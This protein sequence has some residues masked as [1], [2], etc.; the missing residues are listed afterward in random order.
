MKI[1]LIT[2]IT[3][4][5]VSGCTTVSQPK[6][7][8]LRPEQESIE[9]STIIK[10]NTAE[11]F[12]GERSLIVNNITLKAGD[13]YYTFAVNGPVNYSNSDNYFF[14]GDTYVYLTDQPQGCGLYSNDDETEF[15]AVQQLDENAYV[16]IKGND[17]DHI[18]DILS[19][20]YVSDGITYQMFDHNIAEEWT[21]EVIITDDVVSLSNGEDTVYIYHNEGS[22]DGPTIFYKQLD[23]IDIPITYPEEGFGFNYIP[24]GFTE[25]DHLIVEGYTPYSAY[26]FGR[27]EL[28]LQEDESDKVKHYR[29]E[30]TEYGSAFIILAKD[31]E[32]LYSLFEEKTDNNTVSAVSVDFSDEKLMSTDPE[33]K[34]KY[35]L[36]DVKNIAQD[37]INSDN[38]YHT[39]LLL[40]DGHDVYVTYTRSDT[41]I[42]SRNNC[43]LTWTLMKN[44]ISTSEDYYVDGQEGYIAPVH[45]VSIEQYYVHNNKTINIYNQ[46]ETIYGGMESKFI[47][48]TLK[49]I[50]PAYTGKTSSMI[51]ETNMPENYGS[52][53]KQTDIEKMVFGEE[54]YWYHSIGLAAHGS[55]FENDAYVKYKSFNYYFNFGIREKIN[56]GDYVYLRKENELYVY[57]CERNEVSEF[58]SGTFNKYVE[59]LQQQGFSYEL[60]TRS[61]YVDEYIEDEEAV[62][63]PGIVNAYSLVSVINI[64]Q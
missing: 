16:R 2:L 37:V 27:L 3:M 44:Y 21:K 33:Q 20:I 22:P 12:E 52:S 17:L 54:N 35:D 60:Y 53:L 63:G 39:K 1:P 55:H 30:A 24:Y 45:T 19:N 32:T 10:Y 23:N 51:G 14:T 15:E 11:D 62:Y 42:D 40:E 46:T 49:I 13:R 26:D 64:N 43:N 9:S 34:E 61:C 59:K 28:V 56:I 6:N 29:K 47:I 50:S 18:K 41:G 25:Y 31:D 36:S 7:E 5:L 8:I 38:R 4:I 57:R 48:P 58:A